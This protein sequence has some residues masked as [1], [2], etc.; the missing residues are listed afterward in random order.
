M[1]SQKKNTSKEINKSV[2]TKKLRKPRENEKI[3]TV[4]EE[5][6]KVSNFKSTDQLKKPRKIFFMACFYVVIIL[7]VLIFVFIKLSNINKND[8]QYSN[9]KETTVG[10]EDDIESSK[11]LPIEVAKFDIETNESIDI[12]E[13]TTEKS[14]ETAE[15]VHETTE[16]LLK[17]TEKTLESA[18]NVHEITEKVLETTKKVLETTEKVS[19]TTEK[20]LET[21]ESAKDLIEKV[22][23]TTNKTVDKTKKT[24]LEIVDVATL[25]PKLDENIFSYATFY[26]YNLDEL[27]TIYKYLESKNNSIKDRVFGEIDFNEKGKNGIIYLNFM[28]IK[29]FMIDYNNFVPQSYEKLGKTAYCDYLKNTRGVTIAIDFK[30]AKLAGLYYDIPAK[31]YE[32]GVDKAKSITLKVLNK[33]KVGFSESFILTSMLEILD[34]EWHTKHNPYFDVED[35]VGVD[36]KANKAIEG[37]SFNIP[38]M[39]EHSKFDYIV[40]DKKGYVTDIFKLK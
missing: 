29:N 10:L 8:N 12:V 5:L 32:P 14:L 30:N 27:G 11:F 17:I 31:C 37:T 2:G 24:Y 28:N 21:T 36:A 3:S 23:E 40:F 20:V 7:A 38:E 26:Q 18:E 34:I 15:K 13:E 19:E 9:Y 22:E 6:K 33:A 39:L 1:A 25:L 35:V 16:K 4:S